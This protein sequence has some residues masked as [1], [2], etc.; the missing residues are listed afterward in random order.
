MDNC[1]KKILIVEDQRII[2]LDLKNL[3]KRK[4]YHITAIC[5]SGEEA[6]KVTASKKPDLI[7]MDI[8]LKEK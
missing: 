4:G 1:K 7:L 3:L 8:L 2:A 6:I 5:D